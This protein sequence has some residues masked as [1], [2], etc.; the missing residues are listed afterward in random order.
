M[1]VLYAELVDY[2]AR[3]LILKVQFQSFGNRRGSIFW[4]VT[5]A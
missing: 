3:F 5:K 1:K 2:R 4:T